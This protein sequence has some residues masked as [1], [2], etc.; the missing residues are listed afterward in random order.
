MVLIY[1][2]P[3]NRGD[4]VCAIQRS[5]PDLVIK[6]FS[7]LDHLF[8][9]LESP[10]VLSEHLAMISLGDESDLQSLLARRNLLADIQSILVLPAGTG[11]EATRKAHT[12]NP[13]VLFSGTANPKVLH[14]ILSRMIS[15]QAMKQR[16]TGH[17][18]EPAWSGPQ[19]SNQKRI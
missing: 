11:P 13:R 7:S 18:W 15:R 10:L 12:L 17:P 16:R 4:M 1:H 9:Y 3:G 8:Q 2:N 5:I 19:T 6:E 14:H